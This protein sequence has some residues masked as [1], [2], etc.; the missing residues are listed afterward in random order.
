MDE[1]IYTAKYNALLKAKIEIDD[2]IDKML[3][4]LMRKIEEAKGESNES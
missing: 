4:E 1:L 2:T 3:Q